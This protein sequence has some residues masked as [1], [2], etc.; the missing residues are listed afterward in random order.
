MKRIFGTITGILEGDVFDTRIDLSMIGVHKP[1]QAGISGSENEGSDSI[2]IS[3]GY[4]DDED[5]GDIIIYTGHGG[6]SNDS[7]IQVADQ[8][9]TR[10]NKALAISCE[11]GFPVRVIRGGKDLRKHT[12]NF[13]Y[14]YDGLYRVDEYWSE[15]GKSGYLVWRFRL[16]KIVDLEI[17][18]PDDTQEQEIPYSVSQRK[19]SLVQ[20]I[21]RDTYLAQDL[22]ELYDFRCQVCN[23]TIETKTGKYIEAAHVQALGRPHDGPDIAENIICLC[24][25]HHVMFDFGMFSINDDLSLL[26]L[27][28]KLTVH[29]THKIDRNFLNYHRK[30]FFNGNKKK[31]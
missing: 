21:V 3:G 11:K 29:R 16:I 7:K 26:G 5:Y 30:H 9:L 20:R 23:T 14:R 12:G 18:K 28:G 22:K 4:E 2:V 25:N 17:I 24:P 6:R 19:L 8:T 27:S 31:S 10:G 15:I 1:T 13:G